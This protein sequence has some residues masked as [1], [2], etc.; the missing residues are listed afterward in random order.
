M[1]IGIG[2]LCSSKPRPFVPRPDAVILMADTM[3]STETDSTPELHKLYVEGKE[4]LFVVCAGRVELASEVVSMFQR[5]MSNLPERSHG[6]IWNALNEAVHDHRMEHFRWDVVA[7]RHSFSP[8]AVLQS[9]HDKLIEDWQSY[10]PGLQMI[11]GTFDDSSMALLY[12]VGQLYDVPGWVHSCEF[13]GFATIGSG[14]TNAN[15]WLNFRHQQLGLNPRQSAYH[16]Y[17]AKV[18]ASKA[19]TV[20]RNLELVIGFADRHYLLT[21]E[22]AAMDGC[23]ISMPEMKSMFK[24]YGPQETNEL[25]HI[26]PSVSGTRKGGK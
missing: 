6:N 22:N 4:N 2:V 9:Q 1:T 16:A 11:V 3:G 23:P 21:E 17:E 7:A 14:A 12:Y 5:K 8:G 24:K 26:K 13:P 25:G 15:C 18:M 10:D 20:N 19:P